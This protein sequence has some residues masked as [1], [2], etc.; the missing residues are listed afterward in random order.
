MGRLMKKYGF[1]TSGLLVLLLGGAQPLWAQRDTVPHIVTGMIDWAQF[2]KSLNA[3]TFQQNDMT[4]YITRKDSLGALISEEESSAWTKDFHYADVN[5]DRYLDAF[6][7]GATKSKG[8]Y[9]TYFMLADTGLRFPI[10]LEAPGYIHKITPRKD[11]IEFILREDAHGKGYLHKITEYDYQYKA[12]KLTMGWQVQMLS[13]TEVPIMHRHEPYSLRL[14]TELRSAPRAV[15]EPPMDYN[16]DGKFE[17]VGNVV[18]Q[19]DAGT[20][21]LRY[22]ENEINGVKWSFV[23]VL[24][25][26]I[27]NPIFQPLPAIQMAYAGWILTEAITGR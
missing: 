19:L 24:K 3:P 5:G 22:A 14:P 13:N 1:W 23:L 4:A 21:L 27:K 11:D 10:K 17:S 12:S 2:K 8:G 6:F 18:A 20:P 15:N 9:Y 25:A 26:P 16:A 7:S